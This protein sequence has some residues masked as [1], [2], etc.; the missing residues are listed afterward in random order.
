MLRGSHH[1][2]GR[3]ARVPWPDEREIPGIAL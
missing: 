3:R 2:Q 1:H